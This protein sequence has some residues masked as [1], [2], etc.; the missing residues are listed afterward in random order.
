MNFKGKFGEV[1]SSILT[2]VIIGSSFLVIIWFW[3][4]LWRINRIGMSDSGDFKDTY[5]TLIQGLRWQGTIGLY[6]NLLILLRWTVTNAIMIV[7]CNHPEFQIGLLLYISVIF[8]V[9]IIKGRP[10]P[11]IGENLV[12][13]FNEIMISAYLYILIILTDF[14]GENHH[15]EAQGTALLMVLGL[16]VTV[17]F[18]KFILSVF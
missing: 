9:L 7:L 1:F 18:G 11:S 8:Q 17:N 14:F 12:A 16:S 10:M 5:G 2:V 4:V 13:F 15:R 6:W 3:R